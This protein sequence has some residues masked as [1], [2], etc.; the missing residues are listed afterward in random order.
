MNRETRRLTKMPEEVRQELVPL[1]FNRFAIAT[2]EI[3]NQ[4]IQKLTDATAEGL[5]FRVTVSF[6]Q[7]FLFQ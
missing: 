5:R 7:N 1:Y 3:D 6:I 4:K 2:E